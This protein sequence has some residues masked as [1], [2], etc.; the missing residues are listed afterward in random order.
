MAG[1]F[2]SPHGNNFFD[3]SA[4]NFWQIDLHGWLTMPTGKHDGATL[5]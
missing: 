5:A 4:C 1:T 3:S 2:A